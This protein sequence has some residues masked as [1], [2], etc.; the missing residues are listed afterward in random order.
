MMR[1]N[2]QSGRRVG[3]LLMA[4]SA[5]L[6]LAVLFV[7]SVFSS[8]LTRAGLIPHPDRYTAL[9]FTDPEALVNLPANA[10]RIV[11]AF[12]VE[13]HEA[14]TRSYGYRVTAGTSNLGGAQVAAGE[15][16]VV[17]GRAAVQVVQVGQDVDGRSWPHGRVRVRVTLTGT[18]DAISFWTSG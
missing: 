13:N 18:P 10:H 1:T 17:S 9:Y 12:T 11:F 16:R 14:G 5:A 8:T 6:V 4:V 15:L 7:P 2:G 3:G